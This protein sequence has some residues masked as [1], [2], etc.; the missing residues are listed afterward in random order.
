MADVDIE[1]VLSPKTAEFGAA[2][3]IY[4]KALPPE[5]RQ[6][7]AVFAHVLKNRASLGRSLFH[8]VLLK[9][10][11]Q[12]LGMAHFCLLKDIPAG[13]IDYIAIERRARGR[14]YGR[15]LIQGMVGTLRRDA[16]RLASPLRGIYAEIERPEDSLDD[17]AE[18]DVRSRRTRFFSNLGFKMVHPIQYIQPAM[19]KDQA[20][21]PLHLIF[22]PLALRTETLTKKELSRSLRSIYRHIYELEC[23]LDPRMI[24]RCFRKVAS[25]VPPRGARLISIAAQEGHPLS[26]LPSKESGSE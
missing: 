1:E 18:Y 25:S 13:F 22:L 10:A 26:G 9:E 14:G 16:S 8:L 24:A 17:K 20:E 11:G 4:R 21:I 5:V 2:M 6:S 3:R 12:A 15:K 23:S 19:E 7:E